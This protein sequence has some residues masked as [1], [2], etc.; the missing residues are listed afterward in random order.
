MPH[1]EAL[2]SDSLNEDLVNHLPTK[3]KI[4]VFP[5]KSFIHSYN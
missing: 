4:V 1:I 3:A 5:T 2:I